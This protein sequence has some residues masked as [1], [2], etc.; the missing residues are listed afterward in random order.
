MTP[1]Q[2]AEA[3]KLAREWLA[4]WNNPVEGGGRNH[5]TQVYKTDN[6][7][8]PGNPDQVHELQ[9]TDEKPRPTLQIEPIYPAELKKRKIGGRVDIEFVVDEQGNV[10]DAIATRSVHPDFERPALDAIRRWK[11][12]PGKVNGKPVKVRVRAPLVFTPR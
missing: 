6:S 11:F 12:T 4:N 10:I 9:E 5:I 1:D 8:D 3:Q 2:I 7:D